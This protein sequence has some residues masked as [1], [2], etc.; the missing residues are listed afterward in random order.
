MQ[1]KLTGAQAFS[2]HPRGGV[3]HYNG[4]TYTVTDEEFG[5]LTAG[6]QALYQSAGDTGNQLRSDMD[7]QPATGQEDR[8]VGHDAE[9]HSRHH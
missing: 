4:V 7:A 8:P 2:F 9:E 6:E 1:I 3:R 5:L